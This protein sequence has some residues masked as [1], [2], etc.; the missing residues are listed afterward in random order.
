MDGETILYD[1]LKKAHV[2]EGDLR[3]KLREANVL[4][5]AQIRAV[6]FE[7]TGDIA[8]LHTADQ[9]QKLK[10]WLLEGVGRN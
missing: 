8:V 3:A 1:N 6:V 9:D 2:T 10:E 5:L 4:D 7:S